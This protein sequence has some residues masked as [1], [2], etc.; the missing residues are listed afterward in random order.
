MSVAEALRGTL[1]LIDPEP[2][3]VI[4]GLI[5]YAK[6]LRPVRG[7]EDLTVALIKYFEYALGQRRAHR[8]L[9]GITGEAPKMACRYRGVRRRAP[10]QPVCLAASLAS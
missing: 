8:L 4:E 7:R 5:D 3:A 1:D 2:S 10:T 9:A 6:Q